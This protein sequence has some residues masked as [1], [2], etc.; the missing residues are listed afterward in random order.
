MAPACRVSIE[1]YSPAPLIPRHC[2]IVIRYP[3]DGNIVTIRYHAWGIYA[4]PGDGG[5]HIY[6]NRPPPSRGSRLWRESAPYI[7]P[8]ATCQ[9]IRNSVRAINRAMDGGADNYQIFPRND[10]CGKKSPGCNSNYVSKCVLSNCGLRVRHST[11]GWNHHM[12]KC[13][14]SRL[15]GVGP[16][17]GCDCQQW[18]TIDNGWCR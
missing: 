3:E 18:K 16:F 15:A 13:V 5:C 1:C 9:C 17:C 12:K 6:A 11:P 7:A 10:P 2:G 14:K 4:K 8:M